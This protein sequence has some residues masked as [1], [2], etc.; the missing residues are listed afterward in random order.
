MK[1]TFIYLALAA[2]VFC[3]CQKENIEPA[4]SPAA[5][6]AEFVAAMENS[7]ETKIHLGEYNN[8][9]RVLWEAGNKVAVCAGSTVSSPYVVSEESDGEPL[10][11]LSC[12][13][14]NNALG[15]SINHHVAYYPY[16]NTGNVTVKYNG[17]GSYT[18]EAASFS[19]YQTY[20]AGSFPDRGFPLVAV[21]SGLD[22]N[23][24]NFKNAAGGICINLYGE[25]QVKSMVLKSNTSGQ[26]IAGTASITISDTD[27]EG[28]VPTSKITGNNQQ[29]S[30]NDINTKLS[31]VVATPF[32]IGVAPQTFAD[33]F[34]VVVYSTDGFSKTF[35]TSKERT[36]NRSEILDMPEQSFRY[37]VA[38]LSKSKISITDE[39]KLLY[40]ETSHT[41]TYVVVGDDGNV[42]YSNRGFTLAGISG[43]LTNHPKLYL[44]I[45]YC[46]VALKIQV[47]YK[48]TVTE[49]VEQE[50]G[51]M[52]TKT[53]TKYAEMN[54][55]YYSS[56]KY[57]GADVKDADISLNDVITEGLK[58]LD[59]KYK[60]MPVSDVQ[61]VLSNVYDIRIFAAGNNGGEPANNLTLKLLDAYVD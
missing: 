26:V 44:R 36:V 21:S 31:S 30:L 42:S 45:G 11:A 20:Q 3:A 40:D 12:S 4:G 61:S 53:T 41:F 59:D 23:S 47:R 33:G 5:A 14:N 51:T 28:S 1:R 15:T 57:T 54:K 8:A 50:D 18:F 9:L 55:S 34:N 52:T 32:Y 29:I 60:D 25:A 56:V 37:K 13:Q 39:E 46:D 22:D 27:I 49:E 58:N 17:D 16:P 6:P 24:L 19:N 38:D 48:Y 35:S 10:A 2:S 7:A 43:D